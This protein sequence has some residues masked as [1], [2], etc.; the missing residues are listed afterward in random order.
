MWTCGRRTKTN[1]L[2]GP[3]QGK[4]NRFDKDSFLT[5]CDEHARVLKHV[6]W[7]FSW[8]PVFRELREARGNHFHLSWYFSDSMVPSYG[9]K[10]SW[11][12]L[13]CVYG[14]ATFM[15][16]RSKTTICEQ[17]GVINPVEG[18]GRFNKLREFCRKYSTLI[19]SQT[20]FMVSC[21]RA[22]TQ[23]QKTRNFQIN[24]HYTLTWQ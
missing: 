24:E 10:N 13:V 1:P 16:V 20:D 15:F 6:L 12:D 21:C 2:I 23:Q 22:M 8:D 5:C 17:M 18:S 4:L 3:F 14:M 9:R 11:R 7:A 19:A